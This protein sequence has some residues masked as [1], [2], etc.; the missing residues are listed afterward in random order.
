[1]QN[2]KNEDHLKTIKKTVKESLPPHLPAWSINR[3][4]D[5]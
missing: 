3:C 4:F 5:F 2:I 1:M